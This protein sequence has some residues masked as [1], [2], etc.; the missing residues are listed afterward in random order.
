M[1]NAYEKFEKNHSNALNALNNEK[2][3]KTLEYERKLKEIHQIEN[4]SKQFNA[5]KKADANY[6]Q[7]SE[8][9]RRRRSDLQN[10][11][12]RNGPAMREARHAELNAKYHSGLNRKRGENFRSQF[13]AAKGDE[14]ERAALIEA[15]SSKTRKNRKNR[16]NRRNTRRN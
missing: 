9:W 10:A 13:A 4:S 3:Q 16:K 11:H 14:K 2:K 5:E 7:Y 1:S 6:R 8:N 15:Y 12:V